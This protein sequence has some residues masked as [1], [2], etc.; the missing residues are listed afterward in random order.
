MGAPPQRAEYLKAL[1]SLPRRFLLSFFL[2]PRSSLDN[3]KKAFAEL[4][5]LSLHSFLWRASLVF[6]LTLFGRTPSSLLLRDNDNSII[7]D[8]SRYS[9]RGLCIPYVRLSHFQLGFSG[10]DR[11]EEAP[12]RA[13]AS[14]GWNQVRLDP[15]SRSLHIPDQGLGKRK[16]VLTMF[17]SIS[18]SHHRLCV[19]SP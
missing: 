1:I 12:A 8:N 7:I 13:I 11:Q 9:L 17:L 18:S 10:M 15:F 19:D 5:F 2:H 6:D 3:L 16:N 4:S 14:R